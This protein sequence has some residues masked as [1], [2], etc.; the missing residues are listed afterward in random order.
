MICSRALHRHNRCGGICHNSPRLEHVIKELL[1]YIHEHYGGWWTD[2]TLPSWFGK[3]IL[4][5][6]A[7]DPYDVFSSPLGRPAPQ[8]RSYIR[9]DI[10]HRS[11]YLFLQELLVLLVVLLIFS[12]A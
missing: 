2:A 5:A 11:F 10:R 1:H 4:R 3:N 12:L 6:M 8:G 9:G 7:V